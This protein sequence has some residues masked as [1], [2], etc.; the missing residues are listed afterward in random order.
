MLLIVRSLTLVLAD[1][2]FFQDVK[3]VV[4]FPKQISSFIIK[5]LSAVACKV[6]SIKSAPFKNA[7]VY[8]AAECSGY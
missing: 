5:T 6:I 2:E 3:A 7:S 8:A 4:E 1:E